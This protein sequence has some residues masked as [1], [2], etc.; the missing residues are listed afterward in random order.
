MSIIVN[1]LLV[2]IIAVLF[3]LSVRS[4]VKNFGKSCSTCGS[5]GCGSCAKSGSCGASLE[6]LENNFKGSLQ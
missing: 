5:S 1:V 2:A 4:F 3:F 6:E